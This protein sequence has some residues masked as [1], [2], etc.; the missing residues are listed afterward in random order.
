MFR[1]IGLVCL[2]ND[3]FVYQSPSF[4]NKF[5]FDLENLFSKSFITQFINSLKISLTQTFDLKTLRNL[6]EIVESNVVENFL[7]REVMTIVDP[8]NFTVRM[9]AKL[10][11]SCPGRHSKFKNRRYFSA[12][13]IRFLIC[14]PINTINFCRKATWIVSCLQNWKETCESA[15]SFPA[16][17]AILFT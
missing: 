12:T 16:F 13:K 9:I 2:A 11:V 6:L 3:V 5:P 17:Y 4:S 14:N 10:P 7:L 1:F 8:Q 15:D